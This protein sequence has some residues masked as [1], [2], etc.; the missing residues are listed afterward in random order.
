MFYYNHTRE[1][2]RIIAMFTI[3][4]IRTVMLESSSI[5]WTSACAIAGLAM[6]LAITAYCVDGHRV[7]YDGT[8][9][10]AVLNVTATRTGLLLQSLLC[11]LMACGIIFFPTFHDVAIARPRIEAYLYQIQGPHNLCTYCKEDVPIGPGRVPEEYA[12]VELVR[13]CW[14][15]LA[16]PG[17]ACLA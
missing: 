10:T 15:A 4:P 5:D 17:A 3:P 16:P 1:L 7:K 12:H 13:A 2:E 9:E 6:I 14:T 11:L 8:P